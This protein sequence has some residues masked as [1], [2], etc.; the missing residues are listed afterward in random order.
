M[1]L[2]LILLA[3]AMRYQVPMSTWT[4]A[5]LDPKTGDVGVAG[6]SCVDAN[7][8]AIAALVPGKGVAVVQALWDLENRNRVFKLLQAGESADAIIRRMTD[9]AADSGAQ[10]RQYG[11]VTM[12]GNGVRVENFTGKDAFD[13]AGSQ[14]DVSR[15]VTVQGNILAGPSVV[16]GALKAF[17]SERTL[18]DGLMRALEAGSR[19]GG[20]VRCNNRQVRQT[21]SAAFILVARGGGRPYAALD[22]GFTDAGK[23]DAP[24]LDISV[25]LPRFAQNPVTELRKKYDEWKKKVSRP[26]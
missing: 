26:D 14:R 17:K 9:A 18:W 22:L 20:D 8:D 24:W 23:P 21:A 5:A 7:A 2:L 6:A 12:G 11:I 13:W 4:I 15:G 19:S 25:V 1:N 16:S 10:D 3:M